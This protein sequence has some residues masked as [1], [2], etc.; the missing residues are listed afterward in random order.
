VVHRVVALRDLQH[1]AAGVDRVRHA[2]AADRLEAWRA[3]VVHVELRFAALDRRGLRNLRI[4]DCFLGLGGAC[5][6]DSYAADVRAGRY[7]LEG[8]RQLV[9]A[10]EGP[11][12][13]LGL[14]AEPATRKQHVHRASGQFAHPRGLG[15]LHIEQ[16]AAGQALPARR[17]VADDQFGRLGGH[18]D[19]RRRLGRGRRRVGRWQHL[20]QVGRWR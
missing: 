3:V 6:R 5:D 11:G 9:G 14:G 13:R 19:A 7:F 10:Y 18:D 8:R 17:A 4:E 20:D 2:G 15:V 1:L 16:L 12:S